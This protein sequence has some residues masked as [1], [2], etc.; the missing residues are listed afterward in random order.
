MVRLGPDA[1]ESNKIFTFDEGKE[2]VGFYG[3]QTETAITQIGFIVSDRACVE[4]NGIEKE[5]DD[6]VVDDPMNIVDD[7]QTG[8]EEDA[9]GKT[10]S[11]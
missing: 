6:N 3:K 8:G 9:T 10:V 2:I 5:I 1:T 11:F 4:E 7:G